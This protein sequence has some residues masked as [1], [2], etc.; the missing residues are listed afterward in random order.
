MF[1]KNNPLPP[2]PVQIKRAGKRPACK[3]CIDKL[4]QTNKGY[5]NR[6]YNEPINRMNPELVVAVLHAVKE[7]KNNITQKEFNR[8]L[9]SPENDTK[10]ADVARDLWYW[11]YI[12]ISTDGTNK[13]I[14]TQ[15][16]QEYLI[17]METKQ[18][19]MGSEPPESFYPYAP[20]GL[21]Y[22]KSPDTWEVNISCGI[23]KVPPQTAGV[24][25]T[26]RNAKTPK[27][28]Y[29]KL[30]S[31]LA[32]LS[33]KNLEQC[34]IYR[35]KFYAKPNSAEMFEAIYNTKVVANLQKLSELWNTTDDN[36]GQMLYQSFKLPETDQIFTGKK[37]KFI[38]L[39]KSQQYAFYCWCIDK[40]LL[41]S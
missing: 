3:D 12:Q 9:L 2:L 33:W 15:I 35:R 26:I 19:I 28:M 1:N 6:G 25:I 40:K 18:F 13:P 21:K 27:E 24:T 41:E 29:E 20:S 17:Y 7:C 30:Q 22:E 5:C 39:P 10:L 4:C 8:S 16:A 37:A 34:I 11:R 23:T 32:T 36:A 38:E 31:V 14:L